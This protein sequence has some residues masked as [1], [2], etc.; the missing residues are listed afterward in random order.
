MLPLGFKR[1][2][3]HLSLS[4]AK[5]MRPDSFYL[6]SV[7]AKSIALSAELWFRLLQSHL[8]E[9]KC[10][11]SYI[12]RNNWLR[13]ENRWVPGIYLTPN[14]VRLPSLNRRSSWITATF[15]IVL[16]SQVRSGLRE[17]QLVTCHLVQYFDSG[18]WKGHWEN[19]L[20]KFSTLVFL[21][22]AYVST[23]ILS[24]RK[25]RT[26]FF[27]TGGESVFST[28]QF[29]VSVSLIWVFTELKC[30]EK[31]GVVSIGEP[32]EGFANVL[33]DRSWYR[34]FCYGLSI[35]CKPFWLLLKC[36]RF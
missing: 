35:L 31:N 32:P 24:S 21:F 34:A 5:S 17:Q 2:T 14:M 7:T 27:Y 12:W 13:F 36:Y 29:T 1:L 20:Q 3:E 4:K 28:V 11:A 6:C 26:A 9:I 22:G 10:C 19:W 25:V 33:V 30:F 18:T 15:Q 8:V 23:V 16:I